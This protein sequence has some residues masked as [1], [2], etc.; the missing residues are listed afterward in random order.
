MRGFTLLET[1]V[2]ISV[3]TVVILGPLA[4]ATSVLSNSSFSSNQVIAYNLA[5]EGMELII[6][7]RDSEIFADSSGGWNNFK[8]QMQSGGCQ[9]GN[10][11][12]IDVTNG[13]INGCTGNC[14]LLRKNSTSGVYSYNAADPVTIFERRIFIPAGGGTDEK[15]VTVTVTWQEKNG[16]TRSF[17]L[18]RYVYNRK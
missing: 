11:C 4:V 18:E 12:Y 3:L 9:T 14:P 10:G 1:I 8:T 7:K 15:K 17:N 6:N 5:E 2:A 13:A 16:S